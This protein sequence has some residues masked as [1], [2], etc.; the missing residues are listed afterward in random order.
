VILHSLEHESEEMAKCACHA[1]GCGC[2]L[3]LRF[4]TPFANRSSHLG[5][6]SDFMHAQWRT[7]RIA[8]NSYPGRCTMVSRDSA[9]HCR[10]SSHGAT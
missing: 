2:G 8:S 7:R 4:M 5:C 10:Q 6:P 3:S 9:K 1:C